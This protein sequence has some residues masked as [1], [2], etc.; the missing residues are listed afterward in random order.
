MKRR[1]FLQITPTVITSGITATLI[2]PALARPVDQDTRQQTTDAAAFHAMRRFANLPSGK[3]AYVERGRGDAAL[4]LHGAPLNGFQWR[5]AIDRLSPYRRCIA[6]D[7][8]GL[9]YTQVPV[10]QSLTADAQLDM[11]ISLL[12]HLKIVA[13]DII[14]SDSGGAVAQLFAARYPTRVRSM[15]LTNCDVEPDSPPAGVQP[16]IK[17]A[18][19]G[20]LADETAK[21]LSDNTLARATFGAAVFHDPSILSADNIAC[22]V[23]PLVSSPLRRQQY[24]AFHLALEPNPL[25]GIEAKLKRSNIPVRIVWG[26]S[27]TLFSMADAQYLDQLFPQSRGI[28]VVPEGKLFFQEEFPDLIAEE[29]RRLWKV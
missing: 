20:T 11:L 3:I 10:Q 15:L 17:M 16:V 21:W 29:A 22:Y 14:A 27:D 6:P 7:F 5:G 25:A 1:L 12:D 23:T 28:R 19:A 18:R 9:G 13:V 24:H 4:F 2:L 8:M 26:G